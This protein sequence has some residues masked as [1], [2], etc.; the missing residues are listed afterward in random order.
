MS[1]TPSSRGL[2]VAAYDHT[3]TQGVADSVVKYLRRDHGYEVLVV[4]PGQSRAFEDLSMTQ[5]AQVRFFLELD[6]VSGLL[7][8]TDGLARLG[9]PKLA[10]F[11]DTHKKPRF[12]QLIAADFDLVFY[13]MATWGDLFGDRGRWLP[14][15]YDAELIGPREGVEPRF[16]VGFVG[17]RPRERT[18]ALQEIAER[19]GLSLL[20]ETTTGPREKELTADLYAQCRIVFNQHV[21]ND[22]NFR[23][24]EAQ[25]C[26]RLL[27]TDAQWNGQYELFR[28][29]EHV[30]YYKDPRDLER[31]LLHY[32]N[33]SDEAERI[34]AAGYALV[35]DRHT[36][37]ARVR[38]IVAVA[39]A[40]VSER[41]SGSQAATVY[42]HDYM[43]RN[44]YCVRSP[45]EARL[46]EIQARLIERVLRPRRAL[47][48]GCAAGELLVPLLERGVDAWGFD[49]AQGLQRFV[50]PEVRDRV[51]R[52]DVADVGRFPFE[53]TGG[54]FDTFVAIDLFEHVEEA[55]VER[56]LDGV[57]ASFDKLALVIS[58]S[59]DFEGHVCVRPFQW[60]LARLE[61]RGFELL[62][63]PRSLEPHE[64]GVYGVRQFDG[65]RDDMSEQ[66]VFFR[67]RAAAPHRQGSPLISVGLV[68]CDR[69]ELLEVTLESTRTAL[70]SFSGQVEWLAF[71]NGSQ[72][73][74]RRLLDQAGLDLVL[75]AR[76]NRGLACA[77]DAL[78]QHSQGRFVL[79]L[80]DDWR[81]LSSSHEWLE[82]AVAVLE[83][84]P[85]VGVVRLRKRDDK[86]CG[87]W[88]HHHPEVALRHHPWSIEP[89]PDVV[90]TREIDG[91][92]VFVASAEYANWTNNPTLCRREV[93]EW[94]GPM[95]AYLPDPRDHRPRGDGSHPGL[96]GAI[97]RRWRNGPW[98]VAKLLDGPYTHIGDQHPAHVEEG[99]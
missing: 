79:T 74:T 99:S 28:D 63:E 48:A 70:A 62:H 30:V 6:A 39:E 82:L 73:A 53:Q 47:V 9:C 88:K 1:S 5:L 20:L 81:C 34:A 69:P 17:S 31:V 42:D 35:R 40:L 26:K 89:L 36:T 90:E 25:G 85:D 78:F 27:V 77:L 75:R 51:L 55:R 87:H 10:W 8:H 19:H 59:P 94:I 38:E 57:A 14:V 71:D 11:V 84:Q 49:F 44:N 22:L 41:G 16:D 13:T 93:R 7:Y 83:S 61:A 95:V 64:G 23:V 29:R 72:E 67:R 24:V 43:V 56:M 76:K 60:W 37:A 50:Y 21:A 52:F 4:G 3:D 66:L 92:S 46:K 80:E 32:L 45:E 18:R 33:H 86:Q 2:V 58:S 68:C 54:R 91:Q 98:K 65:V 15:H 12:H 96:E 97:D